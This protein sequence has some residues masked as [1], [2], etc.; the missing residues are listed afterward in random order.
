MRRDLCWLFGWLLLASMASHAATE[1]EPWKI[2][3]LYWS[4][5]I[6]SQQVMRQGLEQEAERINQQASA[7]GL[8][9]I[10]LLARVAGDGP[11]GIERQMWQMRMMVDNSRP[12]AIIIQPTDNAALAE[13]VQRANLA[14]IPVIAYDQF[15]SDGV[16]ASYITSDN[17]QAGYLGGEY[18][19]S[20]FARERPLRLVL[21]EYPM[22]SSTVERVNGFFDAL[23]AAGVEYQ[24][25]RSYQAVQPDEGRQAAHALLRD[26]PDKGSVDVLF[27][28][29]NGGGLSMI[30]Q[31]RQA[32]R[33]EIVHATVDGD[34]ESVDN[35]RYGRLTRIDSAQF[36][37]MLGATAV[38]QVYRVLN[39][40]QVARHVMIP[41][42]PVTRET[43]DIYP[44]WDGDL[45]ATFNKPWPS[46]T[47]QWRNQLREDD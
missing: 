29:N 28:V 15:V 38:R 25:M 22:V 19:A 32:G 40:R 12:D 35:I 2:G 7:T 30:E 47:K 6:P 43:L 31:L 1:P 42:F 3:V 23:D 45:P 34:P 37:A 36:C 9:G 13:P 4:D 17:Y 10:R 16:L 26:F 27:T 39:G 11:K 24:I 8:R 33:T 5:S 21:V 14:G 44:G 41:T 20:L 46:V 18:I